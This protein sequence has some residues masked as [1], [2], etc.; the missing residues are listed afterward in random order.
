MFMHEKVCNQYILPA[1]F[2]ELSEKQELKFERYRFEVELMFG[3]A[4]P[5]NSLYNYIVTD[6]D[7]EWRFR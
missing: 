6:F 1:E 5:K 2:I 7:I 4:Y 3:T